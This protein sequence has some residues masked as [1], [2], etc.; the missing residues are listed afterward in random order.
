VQAYQ[1]MTPSTTTQRLALSYLYS[2]TSYLHSTTVEG[3]RGATVQVKLL[4]R[5]GSEF[6]SKDPGDLSVASTNPR[7]VD[8]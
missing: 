7:R 6:E 3:G 5:G 8:S 1:E 4:L 2:P